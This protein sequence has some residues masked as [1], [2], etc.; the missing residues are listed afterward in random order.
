MV[1]ETCPRSTGNLPLV[2]FATY[3]A[4][5]AVMNYTEMESKRFTEKSAEEWRQIY[6]VLTT[7]PINLGF[8]D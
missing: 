2:R 5:L 4:L 6:K 8:E 1:S 3:G 7:G